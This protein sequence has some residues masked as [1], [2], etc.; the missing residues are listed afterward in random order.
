MAVS[1][2]LL[3]DDDPNILDTAKDILE[4]ANYAVETAGTSAAAVERL[5]QEPFHVMLV[6]FH[7]PD[8]SG[9]ALAAQ[10][11]ALRPGIL[12][13]LMTGEADVQRDPTTPIHDILIKPVHPPQLLRILAQALASA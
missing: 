2:I 7:L 5:R 11:Q 10:A 12:V 3:V 9:V 4:D 6:D 1:R 13:I 8:G